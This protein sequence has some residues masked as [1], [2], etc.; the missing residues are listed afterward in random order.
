M[1]RVQIEKLRRLILANDNNVVD[2][3]PVH[4]ST[5]SLTCAYAL[6]CLVKSEAEELNDNNIELSFPVDCRSRLEPPLP[7]TYFGNCLASKHLV[8]DKQVLLGKQ[9]FGESV[10]AISEATKSL[11]KGFLNEAESWVSMLAKAVTGKSNST[12]K[13]Y[14]VSSTPRFEVYGTDFGWGRP[15][16]VDVMSRGINLLDSKNGD[17]ELKLDWL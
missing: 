7:P 9:G 10:L 17:G 8:L 2:G 13:S 12:S 16:K 4:V 14:P 11:E 1:P 15:K 6:V 3:C 5:F